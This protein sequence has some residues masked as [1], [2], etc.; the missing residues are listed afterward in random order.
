MQNLKEITH[1]IATFQE[2]IL[3]NKFKSLALDKTN[4]FSN[5]NEDILSKYLIND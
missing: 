5:I 1:Y 2:N 4:I 3:L